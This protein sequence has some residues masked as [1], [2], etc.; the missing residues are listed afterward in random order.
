MRVI[1]SGQ[2]QPTETRQ[3]S[4]TTYTKRP[5]QPLSRAVSQ[6]MWAIEGINHGTHPPSVPFQLTQ[7]GASL[8]SVQSSVIV[9]VLERWGFD[10][11]LSGTGR[12]MEIMITW[13]IKSY[14]TS[15]NSR[16]T[17]MKSCT[18][19]ERFSS[20][21]SRI[22]FMASSTVLQRQRKWWWLQA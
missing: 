9:T 1:R 14:S 5:I 2:G 4:G 11:F 15:N 8:T 6:G 20:L 13:I 22:T 17:W 7:P 10:S 16:P 19:Q 21:E 3:L 12:S 18:V